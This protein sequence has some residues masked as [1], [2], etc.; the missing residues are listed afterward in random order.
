[1]LAVGFRWHR[2]LLKFVPRRSTPTIHCRACCARRVQIN[3]RGLPSLMR[4]SL[5]LRLCLLRLG[6][7]TPSE[8]TYRLPKATPLPMPCASFVPSPCLAPRPL[9]SLPPR[10]ATLPRCLPPLAQAS[11][12]L[13]HTL[14]SNPPF[15]HPSFPPSLPMS[16]C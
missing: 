14:A 15:P 13:N 7:D 1:M 5:F 3:V 6:V 9:G 16:P 12:V 2:W 11:P 4:K 8:Q 10:A